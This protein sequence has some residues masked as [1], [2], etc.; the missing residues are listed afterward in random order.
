MKK[1]KVSTKF[2]F[3]EFY[4]TLLL[5]KINRFSFKKFHTKLEK[6]HDLRTCSA[7]SASN[8]HNYLSS[9]YV[10]CLPLWNE[11]NT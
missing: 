3:G 6:L 4:I 2:V 11:I 7:C 9:I 1:I 8:G 5:K 10:Y